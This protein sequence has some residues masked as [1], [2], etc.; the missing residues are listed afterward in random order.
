[1]PG[2]L[3]GAR[4]IDF[5]WAWAGPYGAMLLALLGAE[6]IKI[7]SRTRIDHARQR[8]LAYGDMKGTVNQTPM[9][10]ELNLNKQ[11]LA[12]N[13][14]TPAGR[15]I[16]Q[17]LAAIS[18]GCIDNFRP[19]TLD[20]LGLG[21][22][23]L[24][25]INPDILMVS[26][27][28]LGASG[29]EK[30]YVGYAPTFAALSGLSH[31]TGVP[32]GAPLMMGGSI[33]L[34][35]GTAAAFAMLLAFLHRERTGEGLFVDASAREA[36][37]MHFGEEFLATSMTGRDSPRMGNEHLAYAPHDVYR[38]GDG[39]ESSKGDGAQSEWVAIACRNDRE[40]TAFC[41]AAGLPHLPHDDRFRTGLRRWKHRDALNVVI[42]TW[43]REHS[44]AEITELLLAADVPASPSLIGEALYRDPHFQARTLGV[45]VKP[46]ELEERLAMAPPWRFSLT[47]AEIRT[48]APLLGEHT[49]SILTGLLGYAPERVDALEAE[50]VFN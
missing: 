49:R 37:A 45:P 43:T 36:I 39:S 19:G 25:A 29:P 50:G 44:A 6:V 33:D 8:A 23:A 16:I 13:L 12:L 41:E 30:Y 34:R 38:C 40:W 15:R 20:K 22:D 31:L 27:S 10:N 47:P 3:A 21:Y 4:F 18:D 32:E 2:P 28:A 35:A 46:A 42:E 1:M 26:A 14:K 17:D 7:E 24:R 48:P 5:T 11:S 9:F